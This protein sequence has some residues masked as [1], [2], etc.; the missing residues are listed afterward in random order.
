[1]LELSFGSATRGAV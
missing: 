1:L